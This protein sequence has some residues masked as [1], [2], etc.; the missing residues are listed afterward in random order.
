V[1]DDVPDDLITSVPDATIRRSEL[2]DPEL[3]EFTVRRER[4]LP[5]PPPRRPDPTPVVATA[6]QPV[7][8]VRAGAQP[9]EPQPTT[10]T[11]PA[12]GSRRRRIAILS[13]GATV[14]AAGAVVLIVSHGSGTAPAAKAARAATTPAGGVSSPAPPAALTPTVTVACV[15][16]RCQFTLKQ[17]ARFGNAALRWTFGD[18]TAQTGGTAMAHAYRAT[19]SYTV[20][21]AVD[22]PGGTTRSAPLA[23]RLTSWRRA[24]R[25]RAGRAGSRELTAAVSAPAGCRIGRYQ[26]VRL[27]AAR[28]IVADGRLGSNSWRLKA[29]AAGRY[30]LE[31]LPAARAGGVCSA[32]TSAAVT[33]KPRPRRSGS[34]T[35]APPVTTPTQRTAPPPTHY[36]PPAPR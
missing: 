36:T 30:R 13:T 17:D 9:D 10:A 2:A 22:L 6:I 11:P 14:V 21:V 31:L 35:S 12:R 26:L 28:R 25:L 16:T 15:G 5:P 24:V 33:V 27:G 3:V 7:E 23:V 1:A 4:V 32:A 18:G 29:P 19:G 20:A 34:G 8:P